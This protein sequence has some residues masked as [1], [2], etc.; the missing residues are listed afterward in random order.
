MNAPAWG[1][2]V[3]FSSHDSG[4]QSFA[5]HPQFNQIGTPVYG[6]FYTYTDTDNIKDKADFTPNGPGHAHQTVLLEWQA[7]HPQAATYDGGAPR[8]VFRI[9]K[10]FRFTMEGNLPSIRSQNRAVRTT[11]CCTWEWPMVV[12]AVILTSM[13]RTSRSHSAKSFGSTRWIE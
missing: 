12:T 13:R 2:K 4:F 8:E 7:K 1:V 10:A 11:A 9:A 5:F 3:H 6:R